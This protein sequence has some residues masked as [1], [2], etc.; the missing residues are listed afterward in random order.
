LLGI[1]IGRGTK[2]DPGGEFTARGGSS[3]SSLERDIGI[4]VL[5]RNGDGTFARVEENDE[6]ATT[7]S[8][9]ARYRNVGASSSNALV[10]LVD[11]KHDVHWLYP[12]FTDPQMDPASVSIPPAKESQSMG[13]GVTFSEIAPGPATVV[14]LLTKQPLTV[15]QIERRNDVTPDALRRAFPEAVVRA[16][17]IRVRP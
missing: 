13:D 9:A 5:K 3:A 7:A 14:T 2:D 1:G 15:S 4:D 16:L 17:P 12:A 6:V 11:S 8:F 10:F